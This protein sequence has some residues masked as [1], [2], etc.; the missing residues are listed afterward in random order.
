VAEAPDDVELPATLE[1][2][3]LLD[4]DADVARWFRVADLHRHENEPPSTNQQTP[5]ELRAALGRRTHGE[6]L[7]FVAR[8]DSLGGSI[9]TVED[10]AQ[11]GTMLGLFISDDPGEPV[12]G[13]AVGLAEQ[14]ARAHGVPRAHTYIRLPSGL[15]DVFEQRHGFH[16]HER[17]LRFELDVA[18]VAPELPPA[19]DGL[20]LATLAERDD[21]VQ[22]AYDATLEAH[23]DM[24]GDFPR[25]RLSL[26]QWLEH[27]DGDDAGRDHLLLLARG[28]EVVGVARMV[29]MTAGSEIGAVSFLGVRRVE[30]GRG[31]ALVLK[32][33][34]G[35]LAAR[36]GMERVE[37]STHETNAVTIHLNRAAG[38]R[39][40]PAHVVLEKRLD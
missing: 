16:E 5:D 13:D 38:W 14:R 28:A 23:D 27:V 3:R 18:N 9:I 7:W 4:S 37:T 10:G 21:L 17:W 34:L 8:D 30:R 6:D 22:S 24:P 31:Y 20:V 25:P 29:R 2:M 12:L 15:P 11:G 33:A 36:L 26:E 19:P 35:P 40:V 32:R 39:E 1:R